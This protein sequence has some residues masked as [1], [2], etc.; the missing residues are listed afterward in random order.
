MRGG[1]EGENRTPPQPSVSPCK[2]Q[3]PA[4]GMLATPAFSAWQV[5]QLVGRERLDRIVRGS[6][7][8]ITRSPEA[9]Q[10]AVAMGAGGWFVKVFFPGWIK[11]T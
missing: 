10:A 9:E 4:S 1:G 8:E 5:L 3:N 7:V 6:L 2:T 11:G